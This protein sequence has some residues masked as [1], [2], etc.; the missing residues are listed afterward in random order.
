MG[1]DL[2]YYC[3][4]QMQKDAGKFFEVIPVNFGDRILNFHSEASGEFLKESP[5]TQLPII[6]NVY[7]QTM[8]LTGQ[9]S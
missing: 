3:Y 6:T 2:Q 7:S 9:V 5:S 8:A 4:A 1:K